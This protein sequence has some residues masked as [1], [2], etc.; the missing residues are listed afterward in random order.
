MR[1]PLALPAGPEKPHAHTPRTR[2]C[3]PR[4]G[5]GRRP[6]GQ[7][8]P[9][10]RA[11]GHGGHGRGAVAGVPQA[12]SGQPALVEPR[13]LRALERP[14]LDDAVCGAAPARLSRC[15]WTR[16]VISASSA[17][18]PPGHPEHDLA[19]GI[20]TTTGP[21]GQGVANAVG[22]ALAEKVLAA[23]FNRPDLEIVDHHTWVFCGDGC[24]MEG[25]SHEAASLAGTL[26]ARQTD[27]SVRRATASRSTA[28]WWA[29]SRT[30]RPSASRAYG[31]QV[32][33]DVDG[34]DGEA[35]AAAIRTAQADTTRPTLICC[36]TVIG[37]PAPTRGGT[38]KAHGEP[39]GAEEVAAVRK[40]LNWSDPPFVVPAALREAWNGEA[41]GSR[42][43]AALAGAVCAL[44]CGAPGTGRRVRAPHATAIAAGMAGGARQ[45]ASR[46]RRG[47][48]RCAGDAPVL[49]EC[50][51]R[52]DPAIFRNCSAV[53]R[54]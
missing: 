44:P 5:H 13:P 6:A 18:A 15:R 4:P 35:V 47:H 51:Q 31:W 53:R 7:L 50:A 14:R 41:A 38:A 2:Q 27:L 21:L 54:I 29:G 33:R 1:A 32:I 45:A 46:Q 42:G 24:L 30:T 11:H 37:Y 52:A 10:G 28:R 3:H 22:M 9:S 20:E 39:L 8:R 49:A 36:R 26:G 19:M 25:I 34:Q 48:Q 12:Q 40:I 16:C 23:Q 43:R 17:A